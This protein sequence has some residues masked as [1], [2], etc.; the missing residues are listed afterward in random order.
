MKNRRNYY[1]ILHVQPDAPLE[2][3]K[4]SY[5]TLM[6]KLKQHPDL[7]GDHWNAT[8]INEAYGVLTDPEKRAAYDQEL[9]G[10]TS[11]PR[12]EQ[13]KPEP[14][15]KPTKNTARDYQP[16][17]KS[18]C[19]FC[20]TPHAAIDVN[21]PD[22]QCKEC[23]S[24]LYPAQR[25]SLETICNRSVLR[26]ALESEVGVFTDWPQK[27]GYGGTI[28]DLSPNGLQFSCGVNIGIGEIIKLQNQ[29]LQAIA[30]VTNCQQQQP[31]APLVYT[32]GAEFL[33]LKF[34]DSTGTFVSARV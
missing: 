8:V 6:S 7:G 28:R 2:I 3:I 31:A 30:K 29:Q 13:Q 34:E 5:R 21:H 10:G 17:I 12:P 24:P 23:H 9:L 25:L 27:L 22:S 20:K 4:S 15:T 14:R 16:V 32:I 1:R 19:K 33:T 26:V 11:N 18:Y